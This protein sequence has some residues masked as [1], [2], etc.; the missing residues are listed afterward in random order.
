M[1]ILLLPSEEPDTE[2]PGEEDMFGEIS[3]D[4]LN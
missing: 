4:N 3:R 1:V 2:T